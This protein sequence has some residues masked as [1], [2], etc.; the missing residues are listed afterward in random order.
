M[1]TRI[2]FCFF[3]QSLI[4]RFSWVLF[5]EQIWLAVVLDPRSSMTTKELL[6][7]SL[8]SLPSAPTSASAFGSASTSASSLMP[9]TSSFASLS[10]FFLDFTAKHPLP[11]TLQEEINQDLASVPSSS[12]SASSSSP[13][14]SST[15]AASSSCSATG[16]LAFLVSVVIHA[17]PS[18]SVILCSA[19]E[20]ENGGE[21][22][23]EVEP[24]VS[25]SAPPLKR[26]K[27]TQPASDPEYSG[28]F[29]AFQDPTPS[30]VEEKESNIQ[31]EANSWLQR[32]PQDG[33]KE[34]GITRERL[35]DP[36]SIL[37]FWKSAERRYPLLSRWSRYV[38][39]IP[40]TSA[41]VERM[42]HRAKLT[43]TPLRHAL[44]ASLVRDELFIAINED[45]V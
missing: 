22:G 45:Q 2:L 6:F 36:A 15:A 20:P 40:A 12:I 33:L 1:G 13:P 16:V 14:S 8:F 25:V 39:A 31:Q 18:F 37:L 23:T 44:S 10:S 19:D 5:D 38:F 29:D 43:V 41:A 21:D 35:S 7:R 28:M 17:P 11:R 3:A 34:A 30:N 26:I 24:S 27:L 32:R 9:L 42:W 4:Q